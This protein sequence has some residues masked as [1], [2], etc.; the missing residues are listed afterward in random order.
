MTTVSVKEHY[1][2]LLGPV[3]SWML[4]DMTAAR[5]NARTELCELGIDERAPGIAIDLGAGSGLYS[6]PLA[7]LGFSVVAI[8]SCVGLLEELEKSAGDNQVRP[9]LG[10][11][12]AFRTYHPGQADVILCMGDTLTHLPTRES[13]EELFEEMK[14]ALE[15]EGVFVATFRDYV[16][17][18][19][20]GT[21]RFIPVR[22]D[23]QHILTCFLEYGDEVVTVHDILHSRN[24]SGWM[25]S[26]SAYTKL[27]LD[28]VWVEAEL[29]QLGFRTTL[30]PGPRGMLRLVG[31]LGKK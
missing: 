9:V 7:E 19:L 18:P 25:T 8:D 16:S 20:E 4:G 6:I 3:Y 24:E 15:P 28:P 23:E 1:D 27:R 10:D 26:V 21:A 14:S 2:N 31:R 17:A 30:E 12:T 13:V 22:S 11:L 5:E 29:K